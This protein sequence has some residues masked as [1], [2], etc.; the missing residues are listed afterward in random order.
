MGI[1][2]PL[3]C[4]SEDIQVSFDYDSLPRKI[5]W[6]E[7]LKRFGADAS[8]ERLRFDSVLQYVTF[9]KVQ[10]FTK[11]RLADRE[12]EA[13]EQSGMRQTG[14]SGRKDMKYFLDWL[15]NKGVRHIIT[16]SVEDSPDPG[17]KVHS[18]QVIQES[19]ERFT[20]E[21]LDWRKTDLDPETILHI[22]SKVIEA[23][24]ST[25][26][27]EKSTPP[28]PQ[29]LRQLSLKWSGSNSVLRA[30]SEPEGLPLLPR[31][32]KISIY[33]PSSDQ[34]YLHRILSLLTVA[35]LWLIRQ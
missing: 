16:L 21:R 35:V 6:N 24:K 33:K 23:G 14:T 9:P 10:V 19:L 18:D 20:I 22:G 7:F 29:Q 25:I 28:I 31:L 2:Q 13:E 30:W 15:Y 3:I 1:K 11:G 4:E 17:E 26:D 27:N 5:P 12:R 8:S 34:V 32:Q